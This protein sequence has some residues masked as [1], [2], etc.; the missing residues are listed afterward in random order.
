MLRDDNF[1]TLGSQTTLLVIVFFL[2]ISLLVHLLRCV[3]QLFLLRML[4]Q[5]PFPLIHSCLVQ[6][7]QESFEITLFF[8]LKLGHHVSY[9]SLYKARRVKQL[10]NSFYETETHMFSQLFFFFFFTAHGALNLDQS[11]IT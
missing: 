6:M 4:V 5:V 1:L 9:P 2:L 11:L 10:C 3:T 8:D 7:R